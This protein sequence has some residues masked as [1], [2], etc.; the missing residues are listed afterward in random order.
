MKPRTSFHIVGLTNLPLQNMMLTDSFL[1]PNVIDYEAARLEAV[2]YLYG[3]II[4]GYKLWES[5]DVR[6]MHAAT[7]CWS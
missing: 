7:L 2:R 6:S 4:V 3:K 1:E 5:L